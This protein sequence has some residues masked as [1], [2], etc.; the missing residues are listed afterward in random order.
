MDDE[1]ITGPQRSNTADK[2]PH[3]KMLEVLEGKEGKV[4]AR[5]YG[6]RQ[7]LS[8][9]RQDSVLCAPSFFVRY[10]AGYSRPNNTTRSGNQCGSCV[11]NC[12]KAMCHERGA[13][14]AF[15]SQLAR[16]VALATPY[17]ASTKHVVLFRCSASL[18]S[19]SLSLSRSFILLLVRIHRKPHYRFVVSPRPE[20]VSAYGEFISNPPASPART[21]AQNAQLPFSLSL[22]PPYLQ[23]PSSQRLSSPG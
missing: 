22:H 5:S 21:L 15:L 9:G 19:L 11:T 23:G 10:P 18:L 3:G 7:S 12:P 2:Q 4:G 20:H 13:N 16:A 1:M 6:R 17:R 8:H 14:Q